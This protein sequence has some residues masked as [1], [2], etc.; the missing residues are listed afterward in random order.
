MTRL[1]FLTFLFYTLSCPAQDSLNMHLLFHWNN[2]SLP[3]SSAHNNRYNDIWGY[4][5]N[6]R[7]Y[8]IIGS[9]MGTHIIDVTDPATAHEVAYI[10]GAS[11][12]LSIIHRDFETYSHYVYAVCDEGPAS[13]QIIDLQYLPDSA[14]VVYDTNTWVKRAHNLAID[15]TSGQLYL[16]G[17]NS[18][19]QIYSLA[20][21]ELPLAL[22]DNT[23]PYIAHD[24]YVFHDTAYA[25]DG[26][27]GMHIYDYNTVSTNALIG[28]IDTYPFK[29]YNHSS[30]VDESRKILVLAD[31]NHG[32]PLKLFNVSDLSNIQFLSTFG[33]NVTSNSIPH[34]PF[35]KDQYVFVSYYHDGVWVFDTS[36][37]LNVTVA[38]YYDT[39]TEPNT[40]NFRGCW[41]VYPYLPSGR[42]LASDMQ[43]G[44]YLLEFS[45]PSTK[46]VDELGPKLHIYPNPVEEELN[47]LGLSSLKKPKIQ[48]QDISGRIYPNTTSNRINLSHLAPGIYFLSILD[49]NE[50]IISRKIVKL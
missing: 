36:D 49:E 20:N 24:V 26:F 40:N 50:I 14:P 21:P 16:A 44:L 12:G 35:F 19:A 41:G 43:N 5:S 3:S 32:Y 45:P 22:S 1:S 30:W 34:N 4:A 25:S 46:I 13:L 6:G 15:Q 11:Q 39:S 37:P 29:G 33:S 47:L 2:T 42:I 8:G 28:I 31:E 23:Y 38:G 7:E 18:N 48:V 9:T 27:D 10:P 17:G